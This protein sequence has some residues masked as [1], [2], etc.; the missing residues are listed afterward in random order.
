MYLVFHVH[1]NFH[2]TNK[3][4]TIILIFP[5]IYFAFYSI[6]FLVFFFLFYS[7]STLCFAVCT[8][9]N[10]NHFVYCENFPHNINL[11]FFLF[12]ASME[13]IYLCAKSFVFCDFKLMIMDYV[14][15]LN[16]MFKFQN[17]GYWVSA[18]IKWSDI[19][20]YNDV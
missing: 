20:Y 6:L 1:M 15:W 18:K 8:K 4:S 19:L 14:S 7:Y 5:H 10:I 16:W 17:C 2:Y 11:L 12:L 9:W 13:K 3:I